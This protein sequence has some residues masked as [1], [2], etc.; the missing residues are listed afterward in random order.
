MS[1][2]LFLL[3]PA[4]VF[5]ARVNQAEF[6]YPLAEVTY[7][8]VTVGSYSAIQPG[9]TVLFGSSAGGDDLGRQRMRK[10]ADGS[11]VYFGRSSRGIHDGEVDLA[12]DAYI[13]VLND[14]RVWAKIPYIDEDGNIFKD[15]DLEVGSYTTTPPPVANAG[16]G[17][18]GTIDPVSGQLRVTLPHE[19]NT[20]FAVAGS[21]ASYAWTLPAGV[22]LV[23]GY[24]LGDS[25]IQVDCDP[26]FYWIALTVTDSNGKSH[27][28]R[29]PVFARDPADDACLSAFAIDAHR[30][31]PQGQQLSLRI[32]QDIDEG[33]Y[34]DG[35]LVMLWEGEPAN[36]ADRSHMRFVGWH[37][38]DPAE[39]RAERT[40][41]LRDTMLEC[42]DVGGKLATLPGFPQEIEGNDSPTAW[43]Q[44]ASPNMDKYLH[45]LL[46]W[47]STAL[48][49]ADWTWTGTGSDFPF[50]ILGS[51]GESLWAQ[52]ERRAR[53]L[54]PDY[55]F[56]C[57][58]QGQ[59]KTL[60]DPLLQDSGDR[61]ATVQATLAEDDWSEI[62][63]VHQRPGRFHWHRGNA[64]LASSTDI[65]AVFCVAPGDAPAQGEQAQ[66][67]GEQLAMSQDDLNACEGHRYARTNAPEGLYTVVL[68][69]GNDR[70]IDPAAMTWVRL[71]I[72]AATAAQ[73]GLAFA[74]AR[75][76]PM[77]LNIRY[78]QRREGL[79]KRVE[80][81]WERETSGTPAVTYTVPTSDDSVPSP[82]EFPF[83]PSDFG[84]TWF[85][86]GN[87]GAL[88]RAAIYVQRAA[89]AADTVAVPILLVPAGMQGL[90]VNV[91]Q[92]RLATAGS[93]ATTIV[94][95]R[96][97]VTIATLTLGAGVSSGSVAV[98][99]PA[100]NKGYQLVGGDYL[101]AQ[102]TAAGTGAV[103]LCASAVCRA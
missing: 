85:P 29:V 62:R 7:D 75:G 95:K 23:A 51:D 50:V 68:A 43:T 54:V 32:L 84:H 15:H 97:G 89:L 10:A 96:N 102:V 28:A 101:S 91:W 65:A 18:A 14:Y 60:V 49:V 81:T 52:V 82:D 42:L 4:T 61:T 56:V 21:I 37:H 79:V 98:V 12:D 64:I 93:T 25:Q 16:C 66:E 76:L 27:T 55:R 63:Y 58:R 53:A 74:E 92:A 33:T 22:S 77:E 100:T 94:L 86:V 9:M 5:A 20:S 87:I 47:H 41:I 44:M 80:L 26:G 72:S 57:N 48:E 6:T 34:P 35:T 45:Y 36:P 3:Q 19:A 11:K 46:Y 71:T 17:M 99:D 2:R 39:I 40:G 78:D 38:A 67:Q 90:V 31:T 1:L 30:I 59:L 8:G 69:D 24:N 73:R 103:G 70:G 13:T 83:S 88:T